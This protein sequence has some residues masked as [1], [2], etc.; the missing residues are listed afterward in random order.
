LQLDEVRVDDVDMA[1]AAERAAAWRQAANDAGLDPATVHLFY[2]RA[3][4]NFGAM[5]YP[6]GMWAMPLEDFFVLSEQDRAEIYALCHAHVL[7][8]DDDAEG[9]RLALLLR[10]E[11]EHVR[12]EVDS[13]ASGQVVA[14][15]AAA[16]PVESFYYAVPFD[17]ATH[18]GDDRFLYDAPWPQ[19]DL[20][21]LPRR[22]LAFV[23]MVPGFDDVC[24]HSQTF[25][26]V[27]PD[28]LLEELVEGATDVRREIGGS[29]S[30]ALQE[31]AA[32]S[33]HDQVSWGRLSRQERRSIT[34]DLLGRV[35]AAETEI[36]AEVDVVLREANGA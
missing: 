10:H 32:K 28:E 30:A 6:P 19:P 20:E 14:R 31:I 18:E 15:T 3:R 29:H 7:L 24:R 8:V 23:L 2:R 21:S 11:A 33:N 36:L 25:P 9:A 12:Q 27:D 34:D 5:H 35:V 1:T 16:L 13:P 22:I 26:A 4:G 17:A